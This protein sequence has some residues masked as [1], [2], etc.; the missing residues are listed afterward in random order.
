MFT[1]IEKNA[2]ESMGGSSVYNKYKPMSNACTATPVQILMAALMGASVSFK[3][4]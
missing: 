3:K 4:F 1:G 2:Y